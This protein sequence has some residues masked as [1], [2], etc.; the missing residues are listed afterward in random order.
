[1]FAPPLKWASACREY[2]SRLNKNAFGR[3]MAA[4]SWAALIVDKYGDTAGDKPECA[5]TINIFD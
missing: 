2:E 1:M 4:A 3:V 5:L